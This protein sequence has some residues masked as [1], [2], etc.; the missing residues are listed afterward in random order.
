ME[1]SLMNLERGEGCSVPGVGKGLASKT[2][3]PYRFG[4]VGRMCWAKCSDAIMGFQ[5]QK[6]IN[7]AAGF[8]SLG[9]GKRK[10]YI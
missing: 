8:F 2:E 6:N 1:G 9:S 4:N 3:I 10:E 5:P 7:T